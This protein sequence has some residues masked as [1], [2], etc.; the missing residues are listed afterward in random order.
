MDW[1]I[2]KRLDFCISRCLRSRWKRVWVARIIAKILQSLSTC[3]SGNVTS[4]RSR[5]SA[6]PIKSIRSHSTSLTSPT[7][8]SWNKKN[9]NTI[10]NPASMTIKIWNRKNNWRSSRQKSHC[11]KRKE[12]KI[13]LEEEGIIWDRRGDKVFCVSWMGRKGQVLISP[14]LKTSISTGLF[15]KIPSKNSSSITS[16]SEGK[17]APLCKPSLILFFTLWFMSRKEPSSFRNSLN[18]SLK[19]IRHLSYFS[20]QPVPRFM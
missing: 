15:I 10:T 6:K 1:Q 11:G 5:S 2:W 4:K 3:I 7:R 19:C 13:M 17:F 14:V 16:T 18:K 8:N 20:S 9:S 12:R